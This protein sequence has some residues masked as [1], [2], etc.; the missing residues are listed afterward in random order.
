MSGEKTAHS[1]TAKLTRWILPFVVSAA[2]FVYILSRVDAVTV[3]ERMTLRVA[4]CFLPPLAIF[5]VVSLL[6]EAVCLVVVVSHSVPFSSLWTAVR[7]KAA[8]YL[9]AMLN[10]ALGA[11]AV[12]LLL[13]RRARM[14]LADAA[15]AVF[16]IGLFDL[17]SLLLMVIV[18]TAM[19]GADAPGVQVGVVVLAAGA[20]LAGFAVLRAPVK[21]GILDRIREL[22]VFRTA[23]TLPASLLFR[24]GVLR[25]AFVGSFVL[26]AWSA[27][28]AFGVSVPPLNLVVN[29]SILLL[30][31]ALPI[32]AAGLGTG[33]LAFVVL[34]E[35][36]AD[37]ETLLAASLT[38]SA[39]L[40][41][42]RAVVGLVFAREFT[43]E[44]LAATRDA[45][46]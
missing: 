36:W 20:I 1:T 35:R 44:A 8:S 29:I 24:L 37:A 40:I 28:I 2:F 12:T 14:S 18:A 41:A 11:G 45:D 43:R 31:A 15:G 17:G 21:L 10:Y 34:F 23:R 19:L 9:L 33:Q 13:R 38:I 46:A 7:I 25:F 22:Q 32:A 26:L 30:I 42:T 4:L 3:V 27:L 16:L 5:L 39:G 6:I